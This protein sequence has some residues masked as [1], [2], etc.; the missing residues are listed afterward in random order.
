MIFAVQSKV[1]GLNSR[2]FCSVGGCITG[3]CSKCHWGDQK[4]H[5]FAL[6][7]YYLINLGCIPVI[8]LVGFSFDALLMGFLCCKTLNLLLVHQSYGL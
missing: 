3:Y 7:S 5:F 4:V 6:S 2:L 8:E 1:F